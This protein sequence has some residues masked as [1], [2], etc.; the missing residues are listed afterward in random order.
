[1]RV[2]LP[3]TQPSSSA[4]VFTT[5]HLAELQ[6]EI[7]RVYRVNLANCAESIYESMW[8]DNLGALLQ[9]GEL[10]AAEHLKKTNDPHM[11]EEFIVRQ[12]SAHPF[13]GW[14]DFVGDILICY[15]HQSY[16]VRTWPDPYARMFPDQ[17]PDLPELWSPAQHE[18]RKLIANSLEA[19]G[20]TLPSEEDDEIL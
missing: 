6:D 7:L 10:V 19:R 15:S 12:V 14:P 16:M 11:L 17:N 3:L 18:E 8:A 9:Y 5:E 4:R 13:E 1:M 20:M 2:L